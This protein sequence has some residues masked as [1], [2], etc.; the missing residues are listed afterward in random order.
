[1]LREVDLVIQVGVVFGWVGFRNVRCAMRRTVLTKMAM[2]RHI[3]DPL[4]FQA[5][6]QCAAFIDPQF[7]LG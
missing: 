5:L 2:D 6:L 7:A 4:N 3:L 1:M